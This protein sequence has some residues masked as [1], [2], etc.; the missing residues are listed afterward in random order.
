[1]LNFGLLRHPLNWMIVWAMLLVASL[2]GKYAI[3]FFKQS[4]GGS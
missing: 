1:M 3:Q 4:A 2:A